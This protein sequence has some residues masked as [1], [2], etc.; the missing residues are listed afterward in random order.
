MLAATE[1]AKNKSFKRKTWRIL[2]ITQKGASAARTIIM[3]VIATL[4]QKSSTGCEYYG[5]TIQEHL[6]IHNIEL[7]V[8]QPKK[9]RQAPS[10]K[11]TSL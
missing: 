3:N 10:I 5:F 4:T 6:Y 11:S 8:I 7:H 1:I 9:K 2:G